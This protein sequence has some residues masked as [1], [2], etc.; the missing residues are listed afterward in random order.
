MLT[1]VVTGLL[2]TTT[3]AGAAAPAPIDWTETPTELGSAVLYTTERADGAQWSV[4]ISLEQDGEALRFHPLAAY[5]DGKA[6]RR[7]ESAVAD[8]RL[9][10]LLVRSRN[11]VWAVGATE[12]PTYGDRA[13][14]QRWNGKAWS[15]VTNPPELLEGSSQYTA[16]TAAGTG[17]L[18]GEAAT[19]A[20]GNYQ[21]A[22]RRY[23]GG[24]WTALPS[25]GL[26]HISYLDDL[27]QVSPK[28]VWAAGIGG[29]AR[30]D[31]KAWREVKLPIDMPADRQFEIA[32]LVVRAADDIWAVGEKPSEEYWRQPLALHFDGKKWT[33]IAAPV[34]TGQFHDL[35][36]VDGRPVAVGG[37]P[38]TQEPIVAELSGGAF[39]ETTTPP[40]AGYLHGSTVVGRCLWAVG[41]A[42]PGGTIEQP[43]VAVG[44]HQTGTPKPCR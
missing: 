28:D 16:V 19:D 38:T 8:G 36:F 10:D 9:D 14:L 22:V 21:T 34:R 3:V 15:R 24:K 23:A 40:G 44:T 42:A 27:E 17:V 20:E 32:Q 12:G 4:G 18:V 7:T 35:E 41:V 43:Y 13:L 2:L 5:W 33:E 30:Y 6:W 26:Q 39:I 37:D 25:A 29:V 11:D 31:G 1:S